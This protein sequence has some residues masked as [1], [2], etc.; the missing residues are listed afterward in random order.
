[1]NIDMKK[2]IGYRA[3]RIVMLS[4]LVVYFLTIVPIVLVGIGMSGGNALS[5]P[6][7]IEDF[8]NFETSVFFRI[9]A[10]IVVISIVTGLIYPLVIF[11]KFLI[12]LMAS[13]RP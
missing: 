4:L 13:R 9:L 12:D 10:W 3:V 6:G 11:I 1:M 5:L 2:I 7:L 8:I